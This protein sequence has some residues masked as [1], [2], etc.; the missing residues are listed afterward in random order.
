MNG[1]GREFLS[2]ESVAQ[3]FFISIIRVAFA[4]PRSSLLRRALKLKQFRHVLIELHEADPRHE[5]EH[6][7]IFQVLHDAELAETLLFRQHLD[8]GLLV[9]IIQIVVHLQRNFVGVVV[10]IDEA[11]V[12]EKARIALLA[13]RVVDLLSAL[14]VLDGLDDEAVVLVR[15]GPGGL[16]RPLVVQHVGVGDE[17]VRLY[18]FY[19]DSEDTRGDHH[20]ALRVL[21]ERE[22]RVGRDFAA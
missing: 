8:F 18:I 1:N 13:V 16:S 5:L 2:C 21:F 20:S 22:L 14:D 11:V 3:I 15:V 10:Q 19:L 12:Q 9:L 17:A 4:P 6:D 7:F